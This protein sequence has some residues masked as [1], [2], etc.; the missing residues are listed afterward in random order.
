MLVRRS[1]IRKTKADSSH[2]GRDKVTRLYVGW[3]LLG[4]IPLFIHSK[5][6]D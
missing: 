3:F 6:V 1:W 5:I 4:V 2:Y